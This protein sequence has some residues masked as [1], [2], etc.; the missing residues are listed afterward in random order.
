MR[1]IRF[2]VVG[3]NFVTDWVIAGARQDPRFELAAVCSRTRERA[4]EF[5]AR[6]GIARTFVSLEEMAAS[7]AIDAV[8]IATPNCMHAAQAVCCM[9]RGKH[10]L[11]EKPMA[12][13]AR[14]VRTMIEAS[15]R[16][17]VALMEA[18]KTTLTPNFMALREALPK[19]GTIRRYFS[20]FCQY[21]SRYDKFKEGIVLNAFRPE[22]SNGAMMDIGIYTIYPMV[23]L[24]GRPR[25]ISASGILL[26][27]GVDAQ[28]TVDFDY[29]EMN[30]TVLYSKIAD[31]RL[32]SE[33]EGE[34]GTLLLDTIHD[35]HRVTRFP[36]RGAASDRGPETVGESVGVEPDR[37]RYYYEIAEFIDLIEQGRPESAVNS[38]ANSLA[39]LEII[40]EVRRQLGVVY[41]ADGAC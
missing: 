1:K 11:C 29:G 31:S 19:A 16:N 4:A 36:R 14:E 41:P 6:H 33:I 28:G 25:R 5:A 37:D 40:D 27:S 35:I 22:L 12:S 34:E 8:Y 10:V 15:R 18:V 13:N 24:F 26:S 39:T 9:E 3:T 38:H 32:P 2:G 30:A 23:V 21:S 17:G 7:D 20:A